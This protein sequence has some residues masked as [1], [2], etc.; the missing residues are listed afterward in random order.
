MIFY[1]HIIFHVVYCGLIWRYGDSYC[2]WSG[3]YMSHLVFSLLSGPDYV[4]LRLP[5][6]DRMSCAVYHRLSSVSPSP[7]ISPNSFC[8]NALIHLLFVSHGCDL[9]AHVCGRMN[10]RPGCRDPNLQ[11][12]FRA[13]D[14]LGLSNI[15]LGVKWCSLFH[16]LLFLWLYW[17]ERF[18]NVFLVCF[19]FELMSF[20]VRPGQTSSLF[21]VIK[22]EQ[23]ANN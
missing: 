20:G 10:G 7:S 12:L 13:T 11:F 16:E 17:K 18:Q 19:G 21:A 2:I 9:T 14:C 6:G 15:D 5:N 22:Y 8:H 23:V 1:N 4:S 3:V